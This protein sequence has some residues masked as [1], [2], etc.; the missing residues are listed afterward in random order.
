MGRRHIQTRRPSSKAVRSVGRCRRTSA[1]SQIVVKTP[2]MEPNIH[3]DD[4][5]I[6]D[7]GYYSANPVDRF[8]IV[9]LKH[10]HKAS[11]RWLGS[12]RSAVRL[13]ESRIIKVFS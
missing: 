7:Q 9:S 8:D 11:R 4:L 2:S 13:F 3:V 10:R 1:W 6:I 5:L 12:L